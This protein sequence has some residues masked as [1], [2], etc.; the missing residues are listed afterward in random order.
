MRADD[1]KLDSDTF[2][3]LRVRAL[4]PG[5]MSG[6]VTCIDGVPGDRITL[7]VGSAGGGVWRSK[8]GGTTWK[9]IGSEPT[10][11]IG[12]IRVAPSN[13]NVVWVGAGESWTRNSVG[14]GD[15]VWRTA[16]THPKHVR[17][18]LPAVPLRARAR[19]TVPAGSARR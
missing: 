1:V 9:A 8:D 4:G 13:P 3:G 15:G 17:H 19:V 5:V 18:S 12:A 7:W 11:S 2:E 16:A 14:Y 10:Q 6:R